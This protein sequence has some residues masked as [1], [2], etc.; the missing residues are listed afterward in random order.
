MAAWSL[1]GCHKLLQVKRYS[2]DLPDTDD[3]LFTEWVTSGSSQVFIM[4][5]ITRHYFH[6]HSIMSACVRVC[7]RECVWAHLPVRVALIN[8]DESLLMRNSC[9]RLDADPLC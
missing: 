1:R 7:A 3:I 2:G 5:I 9:E 6:T 8:H 4:S